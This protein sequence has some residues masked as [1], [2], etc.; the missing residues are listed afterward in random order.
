M[1]AE[2]QLPEMFAHEIP[3]ASM[4][5]RRNGRGNRF[6]FREEDG[7]AAASMRPRRNGRG[8]LTLVG[9]STPIDSLQ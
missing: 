4:R 3:N 6:L 1:A 7:W 5:P 9:D 8:N 2:M